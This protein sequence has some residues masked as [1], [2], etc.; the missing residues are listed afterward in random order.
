[1]QNVWILAG[2]W[3]NLSEAFLFVSIYTGNPG[4]YFELLLNYSFRLTL[5]NYPLMSLNATR[6]LKNV[7]YFKIHEK[8]LTTR[9]ICSGPWNFLL[10]R[11]FLFDTHTL[12]I[13]NNAKRWLLF[14]Y[15]VLVSRSFFLHLL[16]TTHSSSSSTI[17]RFFPSVIF[18]YSKLEMSPFFPFIFSTSYKLISIT[19][20]GNSRSEDS[21]LRFWIGEIKRIQGP[22]GYAE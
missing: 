2:T 11:S 19:N 7:R 10:W 15:I 14:F 3:A 22:V 21:T 8:Q 20:R 17:Y 13:H 1:M 18:Y 12:F 9:W 5:C 6:T 16:Y 4:L